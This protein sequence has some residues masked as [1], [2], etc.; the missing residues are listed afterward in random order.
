MPSSVREL[1]VFIAS[2]GDLATERRRIRDLE[3]DLNSA[4][5]SFGIRLRV[6]GWEHVQPEVGRPQAT[7]NPLVN[8]CDVFVG[9]LHRRWGTPTG[10][11]RSGFEEEFELA[12]ECCTRT[13]SPAIG[14]F[15]A[16][17]SA[18]DVADPGPQLLSVLAF[19]QRVREERLLLYK[20]YT[21]PD[22]LVGL[23]K[24]YL[25][26][27]ILE[28]L[29]A[30]PPLSERA[31]LGT[32]ST[33]QDEEDA[34]PSISEH[35]DL[36]EPRRQVIGVVENLVKFMRGE[37]H[38]DPLDVDRLELVTAILA[39]DEPILGTHLVNRLYSRLDDLALAPGEV[40]VWMRAVFH[41]L[42]QAT[43]P[44]METVPGWK[45][46]AGNLAR[47][48]ESAFEHAIRIAGARPS[49]DDATVLCGALKRLTAMRIRPDILWA[50]DLEPTSTSGD[51]TATDSAVGQSSDARDGAW[52]KL[53]VASPGVDLTVEYLVTVATS[54]DAG[55]I[56]SL[57][58]L[59][60]LSAV[61]SGALGALADLLMGNAADLVAIA[62]S[63]DSKYPETSKFIKGMMEA[64][65][66]AMLI[67]LLKTGNV[68]LRRHGLSVL[69]AREAA[70]ADVVRQVLSWRDRKSTELLVVAA[71]VDT[72]LASLVLE[73]STQDK[74]TLDDQF[75]AQLL[76]A[77]RPEEELLESFT[78]SPWEVAQ[79]EAAVDKDEKLYQA[80]RAFLDGGTWLDGVLDRTL[81]GHPDLLRWT[82]TQYRLLAC[83]MLASSD[84][85]LPGDAAL[86]AAEVDRDDF[87]SRRGAL[88]ALVEVM[89]PDSSLP[90]GS[91]AKVDQWISTDELDNLLRSP[92]AAVFYELMLN[93]QERSV[94][95][96]LSV[97]FLQQAERT[98]DELVEACYDE[99]ER[100]RIEA[101]R[102][103][104][105]REGKS[106]LERFL[107]DYRGRGR[108]YWYNVVC[109]LDASLYGPSSDVAHP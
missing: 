72:E 86:I 77:T 20:T 19:Q 6:V 10:T 97:W 25:T 42:A 101:V 34:L 74:V 80:V 87:F 55:L 22:Q 26:S 64:A 106:W 79:F 27:Q 59:E 16:E 61:S 65:P 69:I 33:A 88:E 40:D 4:F 94:R 100:V 43:S 13:G 24:D 8:G 7:I 29:R 51:E 62:P 38:D 70:D 109:F 41:D 89:G 78:G 98:R 85:R 49:S 93:T 107:E 21:G 96:S 108:P 48:T 47:E 76:R 103:L 56:S 15:F 32:A 54:A 95:R 23:V 73:L 11:H 66:A 84:A 50:P 58:R 83:R 63:S 31:E 2:P 104:A 39:R 82:L 67:D 75:R 53:F 12:L 1:L 99:D 28:H 71:T 35:D 52:L 44:E 81:E 90:A 3:G 30:E 45:V 17:L 18:E 68:S 5:D 36:A 92:S 46:I 105:R 14:M 57:S 37:E 91:L 9:L 60:G 102:A